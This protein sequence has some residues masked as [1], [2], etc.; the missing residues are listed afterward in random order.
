MTDSFMSAGWLHKTN[1]WEIIGEDADPVQLK[2]C[3]ETA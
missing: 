2:V 3:I 1:L